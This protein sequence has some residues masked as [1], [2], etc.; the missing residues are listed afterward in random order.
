[1]GMFEIKT[2]IIDN[3]RLIKLVNLKTQEYISIV[4][5]FGGNVNEIILRK[6]S[7]NYS[8]LEGNTK[9]A[10]ICE[11]ELF[12]GAKLIPFANR[13][14]DGKYSFNGKCYQLPLDCPAKIHAIHGFIYKKPMLLCEQK[15]TEQ[16]AL[17]KLNCRY[18]GKNTGY[19]FKFK[20]NLT[21]VL[22][23][24]SEFKCT[25]RIQNIDNCP[26]PLVDG[27]HPYF[28]TK[29]LVDMLFLKIPA[30]LKSEVDNQLIPTGNIL[31]FE[32][33]TEL[34]KIAQAK[35]DTCFQLPRSEGCATTE[36]YDPDL[37]IKLNVWQ[38][39]GALKYNYLQIY[40]PPSRSSIAIEPMTSNIDAF[41]NK[42]G[43]IVLQPEEFFQAS[44]GVWLS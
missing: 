37:N 32:D 4:P 7:C 23:G 41:N 11:S 14:K 12:R 39:T 43:L 6:D 31:P 13:I 34:R 21:Y 15:V 29:G 25:T 27:W 5:D 24:D 44:Y 19:P 20:M 3:I 35:F 42:E 28:K 16:C 1:M 8:I 22:T 10:D 40:I 26:M 38:E 36:I 33:F 17:I 18:L 30:K 2:S 9:I